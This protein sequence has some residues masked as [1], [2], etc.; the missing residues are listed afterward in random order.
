MKIGHDSAQESR[1]APVVMTL[2]GTLPIARLPNPA[3]IA[4]SNGPKTMI[5][6]MMPRSALHP[7][8]IVDGNGAA[9]T[10]VDD[11]NGEADSGLTGSDGQHEHREHLP[12][13]IAQIGA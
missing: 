8:D 10:E 5:E 13:Q 9:R 4:A 1:S 11:E 12:H 6:I 3:M 7:V 2:A